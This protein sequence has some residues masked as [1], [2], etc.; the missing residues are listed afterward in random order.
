M[1]QNLIINSHNI[2]LKKGNHTDLNLSTKDNN[3]HQT[4]NKN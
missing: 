2:N 4:T 1:I 3:K